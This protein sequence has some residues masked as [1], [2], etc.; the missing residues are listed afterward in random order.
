MER[1]NVNATPK[2]DFISSKSKVINEATSKAMVT[3]KS[4]TRTK[5]IASA[6]EMAVAVVVI[7]GVQFVMFKFDWNAWTHYLFWVRTFAT[8]VGIYLLYRAVINWRF[9][10]TAARPNVVKAREEYEIISK[11]KDLSLKDFLKE[12][13]LRSKVTAYVDKQNAKIYKIENKLAKTMS[14]MKREKLELK[15]TMLK[16]TISDEFIQK[17]IDGI[18]VKYYI[19]FYTDFSDAEATGNS[20][21]NLTR[22]NQAYNR[23]F[24]T[25]SLKNMY[26][27]VLCTAL[28]AVSLIGYEDMGTLEIVV[29][30]IGSLFMIITRIA[31]ALSKADSLYDTTIT[32]SIVNKTAILTEF[33]IWKE[34][35]PTVTEIEKIKADAMDEANK[36]LEEKNALLD[37]KIKE[38]DAIKERLEKMC[39]Q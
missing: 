28:L 1:T 20:N 34:S 32:A 2:E 18:H 4:Y 38:V 22:G 3:I 13:N 16:K 30:L 9:Y 31:T 26:M 35:H 8:S 19:V 27:Y 36:K 7:M 14:P 11:V 5:T 25:Q 33:K 10:K 24:N 15:L 23:L 6:L 17:N 29:N 37:A 21:P 39:V 12:F